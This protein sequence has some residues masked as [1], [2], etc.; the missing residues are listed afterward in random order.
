M[1]WVEFWLGFF[2]QCLIFKVFFNYQRSKQTLDLKYS[3]IIK[4]NY[5]NVVSLKYVFLLWFYLPNQMDVPMELQRISLS[6]N[7]IE[8]F[9]EAPQN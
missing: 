5:K 1:D 2:S 3:I 9:L 6:V 7:P 8:E 4:T